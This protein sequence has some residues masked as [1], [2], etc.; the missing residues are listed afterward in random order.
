MATKQTEERLQK[1]PCAECWRCPLKDREFVPTDDPGGAVRAVVSRSPGPY[2]VWK[3]RPFT[4]PAGRLLDAL[5]AEYGGSRWDTLVTNA[6]L[7]ETDKPPKA[8]LDACRPRLL[9]ELQGMPTVI[10]GGSE[11][12][13]VLTGRAGV[14]AARGYLHTHPDLPGTQIVAT[15]NPAAAL[16]NDSAFRDLEQDFRRA[17][18]PKSA[19]LPDGTVLTDQRDIEVALANVPDGTYGMDIESTG[20]AH[21][22]DVVSIAFGFKRDN[23]ITYT[24]MANQCFRD[25]AWLQEHLKPVLERPGIECIWHH[26]KF[27]VKVLRHKDIGARIDGDTMMMSYALD[28]RPG[29]HGLKYLIGDLLGWPEYVPDEIEEGKAA[30]VFTDQ[31]EL[32]RYNGIDAAGTFLVAEELYARVQGSDLRPLYQGLLVPGSSVLSDIER[33]G[34]LL[35]VEKCQEILEGDIATRLKE[36]TFQA[37]FIAS[38]AINLNSPKQCQE[39]M[40]DVLGMRDPGVSKKTERSTDKLTRDVLLTTYRDELDEAGIEFIETLEEFKDADATRKLI[41]GMVASRH[42][43]TGRIHTEYK[44][45]GTTSG[46]SSSSK[47]NMQNL[48]RPPDDPTRPNVRSVIVAPPG[49][50]LM[51]AD[52]S[53][54]ELRSAA[55]LAGDFD[56]LGRVYIEG[57][58]LHSEVATAFFGPKFTKNQRV[59]A[60]N[61]NFG[62]LYGQTEYGFSRLYKIPVKEARHYIDLWWERFP[63]VRAWKE[64]VE[65]RV[66][67]D[68]V[69]VNPFG[70]QRRFPLITN[71]NRDAVLREGVNSQ[72]QSTAWDYT[73]WSLIACHPELVAMDVHCIATVHDSLV[74]EVPL[75]RREEAAGIVKETMESAPAKAMGWDFPYVADIAW[76]TD[77]GNVKEAA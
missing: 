47:P 21:H 60:K 23:T 18:Q 41:E 50:T 5:L 15:N 49:Y 66:L 69:L 30:G 63:V 10:A 2:E 17:L 52:Y 61:I 45:H 40:Y 22:A 51:Q 3:G 57:R 25:P 32:G 11:A 68:Q 42:P 36:T 1:A 48:S 44:L 9:N 8:A 20:L 73:L 12:V 38:K 54:A 39:F 74:F 70:R 75:D 26:G 19:P 27:D 33:H 43:V 24:A 6:V 16:H 7:C 71:D 58:D 59:I 4:G 13:G 67:D 46:R 64:A 55:V 37:E 28:E 53:Q 56:G 35:D 76:G 31:I 14:H 65:A 34:A 29:A 77:W 62:I 72:V